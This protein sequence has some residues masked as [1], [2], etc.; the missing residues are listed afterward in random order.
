[1][2]SLLPWIFLYAAR[3]LL[4][5]G[6][7]G[8]SSSSPLGDAASNY[9]EDSRTW[10][11]G[12]NDARAMNAAKSGAWGRSSLTDG[13]SGV[14]QNRSSLLLILLRKKFALRK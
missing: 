11:D 5:T 12:Q 4:S 3:A 2:T 6:D 8:K 10:G 14:C 9:V 7:R 13:P 1:M